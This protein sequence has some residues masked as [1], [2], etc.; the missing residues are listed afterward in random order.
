MKKCFKKDFKSMIMIEHHFINVFKI[1]KSA[2]RFFET[3]TFYSNLSDLFSNAFLIYINRMMKYMYFKSNS[4][5]TFK[6]MNAFEKKFAQIFSH[7]KEKLNNVIL[8]FK[9]KQMIADLI[10]SKICFQTN[11]CQL[12]E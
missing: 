3:L 8:M 4:R 9:R 6:T 7:L 11:K 12:I 10:E 2:K 1:Q 5:T